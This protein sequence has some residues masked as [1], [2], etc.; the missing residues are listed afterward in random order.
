MT[1]PR[2]HIHQYMKVYQTGTVGTIINRATRYVWGCALP[3]C[4][5]FMPLNV[6]NQVRGK[7]SLCNTCMEPFVLDDDNMKVDKP[8]CNTCAHPE[9]N[10]PEEFDLDR[11]MVRNQ[12][13]VNAGIDPSQ[14]S[15]EEID[16]LIKFK[17]LEN[18]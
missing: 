2:K 6:S 14:V 18:L 4:T 1:R 3:E 12:I 9:L 10:M 15:E 5:H 8:L 17:K 11:F 13:A 16:R 7:M